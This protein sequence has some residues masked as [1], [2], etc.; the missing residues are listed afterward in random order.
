MHG[1]ENVVRGDAQLER[2]GF[3]DL[4]RLVEPHI[5]RNL[6]WPLN[7][8]SSG[9]AK[10]GAMR[11]RT[12]GA[13]CAKRLRIEPFER[14]WVAYRNRLPRDDVCAKRPA[15]TTADVQTSPQHARGEIEP[16]PDREVTAPLPSSQNVAPCTSGNKPPVLAE[17]QIVN[18]VSREFVPLIE[19]GKPAVR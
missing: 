8:I 19:A 4:N 11:I 14:G 7:N 9:V 3:F 18:P 13:R 6:P 16:G 10:A 15:H 17:W 5:H 1:I 12:G 2:A